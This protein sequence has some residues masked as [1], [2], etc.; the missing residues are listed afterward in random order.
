[1]FTRLPRAARQKVTVSLT[2]ARRCVEGEETPTVIVDQDGASGQQLST[3]NIL[4]ISSYIVFL[5]GIEK[6]YA[7]RF[8]K[9]FKTLLGRTSDEFNTVVYIIL[10]NI[11]LRTLTIYGS[12]SIPELRS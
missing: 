7:G 1:M 2:L 5:A 9:I 12:I 8:N 6:D 3:K 10:A 11:P 4:H